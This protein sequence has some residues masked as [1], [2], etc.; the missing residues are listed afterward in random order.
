MSTG[1]SF[2]IPRINFEHS[3][4]DIVN[5]I[6][7]YVNSLSE[8]KYSV[9]RVDV[10]IR[11][12]RGDNRKLFKMAFV[13]FNEPCFVLANKINW[14]RQINLTVSDS[15]S[16]VSEYWMLLNYTSNKYQEFDIKRELEET[17]TKLS[18]ENTVSR[19]WIAWYSDQMNESN[20]EIAWQK[21]EIQ[22]L[23]KEVEKYRWD[24]GLENAV[25]VRKDS[26]T[27]E[28]DYCMVSPTNYSPFTVPKDMSSG[29]VNAKGYPTTGGLRIN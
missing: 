2:Y 24:E 4:A 29:E 22:R 25:R 10:R 15:D 23:E 17:I 9:A 8:K 3:D 19:K 12:T 14:E 27:Y 21:Q 28:H 1:C 20:K 5:N 11:T 18:A 7:S 6:E 26:L 16:G 13:H